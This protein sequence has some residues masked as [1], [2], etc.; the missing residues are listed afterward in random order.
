M[1]P[2]KDFHSLENIFNDNGSFTD[3]YFDGRIKAKEKKNAEV[4]LLFRVNNKFYRIIRK[5]F[6][7]DSLKSDHRALAAYQPEHFAAG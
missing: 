4:E 2:N 1:E 3:G 5:F 6:E 7:R